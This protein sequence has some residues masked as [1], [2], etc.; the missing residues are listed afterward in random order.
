VKNNILL[1][2]GQDV[3]VNLACL[4]INCLINQTIGLTLG[5]L[6]GGRRPPLW[7]I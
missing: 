4:S 6:A 7:K 5:G 3:V 1:E 2:V